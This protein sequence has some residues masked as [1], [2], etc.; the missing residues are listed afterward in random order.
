MDGMFAFV[1][2]DE[3][4]QMLFAAPVRSMAICASKA[5]VPALL[6]HQTAKRFL[7]MRFLSEPKWTL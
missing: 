6:L 4:K 5:L 3:N 2:W 7:P 1:L